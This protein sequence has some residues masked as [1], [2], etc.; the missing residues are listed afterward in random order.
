MSHVLSL[1]FNTQGIAN[2]WNTKLYY[3][4]N[5]QNDAALCVKAFMISCVQKLY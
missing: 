5:M 2:I 1:Y 3:A 4:S